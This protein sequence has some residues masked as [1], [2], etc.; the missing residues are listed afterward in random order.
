MRARTGRSVAFGIPLFHDVEGGRSG[1]DAHRPNRE[2]VDG[3]DVRVL[4]HEEL[5]VGGVVLGTERHVIPASTGHGDRVDAEVDVALGDDV[6]L[7]AGD[8]RDEVD[9]RW[10][11]LTEDPLAIS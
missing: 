7:V 6:G 11:T 8:D 9:E 1:G 10:I 5:L 4:P 2:V 3:P